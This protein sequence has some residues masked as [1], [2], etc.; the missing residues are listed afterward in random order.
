M[1]PKAYEQPSPPP[2]HPPTVV[3]ITICIQLKN[4]CVLF[5][6]MDLRVFDFISTVRVHSL[7]SHVLKGM[8]QYMTVRKPLLE[9]LR[10]FTYI[11]FQSTFCQGPTPTI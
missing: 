3:L 6:K 2:S 8:V 7:R 9:L 4:F 10:A 1:W 11:A 5:S